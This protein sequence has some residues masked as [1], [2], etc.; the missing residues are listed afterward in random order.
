[1]LLVNS[2][3]M[4][5]NVVIRYLIRV[6]NHNVHK[7][8]PRKNGRWKIN[9]ILKKSMIKPQLDIKPSMKVLKQRKEYKYASVWSNSWITLP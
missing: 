2:H 5:G 4:M 7:I 1:M 3:N 9:V 8:K 6:I